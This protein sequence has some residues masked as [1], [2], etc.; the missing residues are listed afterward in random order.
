MPDEETTSSGLHTENS[1]WDLEGRLLYKR[2]V[3]PLGNVVIERNGL[4]IRRIKR[5]DERLEVR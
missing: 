1:R 4:R 3:L 5:S 2:K